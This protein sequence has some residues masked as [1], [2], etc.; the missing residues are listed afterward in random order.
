MIAFIDDHRSVF[1]VGPICRVLGSKPFIDVLRLKTVEHDP[2]LASDR[3]R[4]DRLDMAGDQEGLRWQP[5][6]LWRARS[7]ISCA[8]AVTI[9]PAVMGGAAD[10]GHGITRCCAGQEGDHH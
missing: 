3:A 8:A 7:G 2:D 4:Q 6:P 1:G 10:E 5:R 9:S